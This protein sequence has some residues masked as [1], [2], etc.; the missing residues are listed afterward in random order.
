MP[1]MPA[2]P[3]S[4]RHAAARGSDPGRRSGRRPGVFHGPGRWPA[5]GVAGLLFLAALATLVVLAG[6]APVARAQETTAS[7][8]AAGGPAPPPSPSAPAG[9]GA[10]EEAPPAA[11]A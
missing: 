8:G 5:A 7:S 1:R 10:G 4:L 6:W 9:G 11:A 3:R 2:T